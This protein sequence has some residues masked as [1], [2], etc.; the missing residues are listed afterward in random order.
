MGDSDGWSAV[1]SCRPPARG[2]RFPSAGYRALNAAPN[3][4][5]GLSGTGLR[6][7]RTVER[8]ER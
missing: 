2:L 7:D 8:T 1:S 4:V 5:D 6:L 3:P